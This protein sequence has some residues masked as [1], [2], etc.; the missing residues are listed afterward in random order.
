M[1]R[2]HLHPQTSPPGPAAA[3]RRRRRIGLCCLLVLIL[4][5]GT[6]SAS[7]EGWEKSLH[8]ARALV[9]EQDFPKALKAYNKA[10]KQLGQ[11]HFEILIGQA[12]C[13][14]KGGNFHEAAEL[15][16][17]ALPLASHD[18]ERIAAHSQ[19]A[20][21]LYA[22]GQGTPV[23]LQGAV[24]SF[25]RLIELSQDG[26][27]V[28]RFN[29]GLA[30]LALER[31]DAGVA[32]LQR[33]V[34]QASQGR[35]TQPYELVRLAKSYIAEPRRARVPLVAEFS[36]RA[37]D[38]RQYTDQNLLGKVVVFDFWATWCGPCV[39][40]V[41]HLKRMAKRHRD[42]PFLLLSISTDRSFGVLQKFLDK[43]N[44]D[45][46]QIH[47]PN[48]TLTAG[49]FK[50]GRYPTY[51]V[52]DHRGEILLQDSGWSPQSALQLDRIVARAL[53]AVEDE[54]TSQN[55]GVP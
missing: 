29:L 3:D 16:R 40:A 14:S 13:L 36:A 38:G 55:T 9:Q 27:P 54:E 42:D 48:R 4:F 41:P 25:H 20:N 43:H 28:V 12:R 22:K 50:V 2:A 30:L 23:Q 7:T 8:K 47:D 49:I 33:F 21:A 1:T 35:A 32:E 15:A 39:N 52:V 53:A 31:D 11:P 34:E 37:L 26:L 6:A 5:G 44:M 18:A 10:A 17:R 46:P 45:W 51:L 19:L 24:E